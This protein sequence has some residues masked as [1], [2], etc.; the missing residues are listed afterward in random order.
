[1]GVLKAL[2][3]SPRN[4]IDQRSLKTIFLAMVMLTCTAVG[5]SHL[6]QSSAGIPLPVM[7]DL[8]VP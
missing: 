7:M 8:S 1:M 2:N 5:G 4:S 6:R 3:A